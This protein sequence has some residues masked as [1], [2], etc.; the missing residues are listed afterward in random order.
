MEGAVKITSGGKQ[1]HLPFS[2]LVELAKDMQEAGLARKSIMWAS[3]PASGSSVTR[4]YGNSRQNEQPMASREFRPSR[5]QSD[6]GTSR[7]KV[8]VSRK[9]NENYSKKD[10]SN[11]INKKA[12]P[13]SP[14]KNQDR[15]AAG[16]HNQSQSSD[17]GSP[18]DI[19]RCSY[20]GKPGHFK[21]DCW[22]FLRVCLICGKSHSMEDCP[23]FD[24][25]Y[26]NRSRSQ[27]NRKGSSSN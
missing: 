24:P 22:R 3:Q 25:S 7:N 13:Y 6:Q 9:E 17:G 1:K 19:S 26:R 15:R 27:G 10:S 11:L 5:R 14:K 4:D 8:S 2:G 21:R 16:G 23:K 20:C 12:I 18:A